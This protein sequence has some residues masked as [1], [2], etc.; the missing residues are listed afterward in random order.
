[1]FSN[2]DPIRCEP[3]CCNHLLKKVNKVADSI[4]EIQCMMCD[5][6]LVESK[7]QE[8]IEIVEPT[9]SCYE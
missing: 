9:I 3:E 5:T 6:L 2:V 7:L 1:M 8:R 4:Y